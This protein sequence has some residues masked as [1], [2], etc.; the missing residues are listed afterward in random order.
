MPFQNSIFRNG[1]LCIQVDYYFQNFSNKIPLVLEKMMFPASL[2]ITRY[3]CHLSSLLDLCQT[4][5]IDQSLL[6]C[7]VQMLPWNILLKSV[8]TNWS[9]FALQLEPICPPCLKHY[10]SRYESKFDQCLLGLEGNIELILYL[11]SYYY[12]RQLANIVKHRESQGKKYLWELLQII[13]W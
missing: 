13:I 3:L 10:Q 5:L 1:F 6:S 12:S 8:A 2:A 4:W 7:G 9:Q 11:P